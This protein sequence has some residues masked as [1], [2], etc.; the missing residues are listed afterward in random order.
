MERARVLRREEFGV[1]TSARLALLSVLA[2]G[3][4]G[5]ADGSGHD[6]EKDGPAPLKGL[7]QKSGV[8]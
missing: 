1:S 5:R 8:T 3:R 2:T 4:R 7:E 6:A